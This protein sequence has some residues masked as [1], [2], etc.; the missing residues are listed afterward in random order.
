M[1]KHESAELILRLYELRREEKMRDARNWFFGFVPQTADDVLS[2][3]MNP[4]DSARYRM[5]SS[6]WDMAATLVNHGGIDADMFNE[7]NGE[8]IFVFAKLEPILAEI[9]EKMHNPN[10][11][12]N[13]EKLVNAMPDGKERVARARAT[14]ERMLAARSQKA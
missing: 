14:V 9:R 1:S 3:M 13:L 6:Y 10:L 2:V 12:A 11:F 8:H 4:E 5:V 7:A